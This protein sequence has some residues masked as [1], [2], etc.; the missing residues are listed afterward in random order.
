MEKGGGRN[1][2]LGLPGF[3][4][5]PE[6]T[7]GAVKTRAN[8]LVLLGCLSKHEGGGGMRGKDVGGTGF[9]R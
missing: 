4:S 8:I 3:I 5:T 9:W 2:E 6:V 7:G 1:S